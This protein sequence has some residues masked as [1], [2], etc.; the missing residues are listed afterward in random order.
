MRVTAKARNCV[1]ICDGEAIRSVRERKR[2]TAHC[3]LDEWQ[4]HWWWLHFQSIMTGWFMM[5]FDLM[6][7]VVVVAESTR[8]SPC[9]RSK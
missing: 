7:V 5:G 2:A 4:R 1:P 3:A 8:N 9:V 6:G